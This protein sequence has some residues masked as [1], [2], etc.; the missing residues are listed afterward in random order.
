M[1]SRAQVTVGSEGKLA[2][3]TDF[4]AL[5][6]FAW[7]YL[8]LARHT[9]AL[10]GAIE[11]LGAEIPGPTAFVLS[12]H[13]WLY[14]TVFVGAGILVVAKEAWLRDK[15]L[16]AGLTFA[17]ALLVLWTSDYFKAVLFYPMLGLISK[18]A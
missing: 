2:W 5:S 14:P 12:H 18:L 16:S 10:R 11:G 7:S 17:I 9:E 15:R 3:A 13:G 6:Y 8:S 1:A 4:V